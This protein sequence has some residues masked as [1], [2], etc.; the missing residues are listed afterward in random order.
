M[1]AGRH[2]ELEIP[3]KVFLSWLLG[4]PYAHSPKPRHHPLREIIAK[5]HGLMKYGLTCEVLNAELRNVASV[6]ISDSSG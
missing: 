1:F 6:P 3:A 4:R 2:F 5:Q